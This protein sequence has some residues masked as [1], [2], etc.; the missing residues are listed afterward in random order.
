VGIAPKNVQAKNVSWQNL[1]G[2]ITQEVFH[3][4]KTGGDPSGSWIQ[5]H[6]RVIKY[7]LR[8]VVGN[9]WADHLVL[10]AAVLTARRR[11]V[12]TVEH[13]LRVLHPRFALLFPALKLVGMDEWKPDLHFPLYMNGDLVP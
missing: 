13:I 4:P 6:E 9:P 5:V 7:L 1:A 2:K 10:I 8:N 3:A 12:S 11:D